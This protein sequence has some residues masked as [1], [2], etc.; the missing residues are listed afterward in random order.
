MTINN[1]VHSITRSFIIVP[2]LATTLSMNAFTAAIEKA[3][4]PTQ[5]SAQTPSAEEVELQATLED[6]AAKIDAY[7]AKNDMPLEGYGMKMVLEAQK[8]DLDWRIIPA[9]AVRESTGGKH[10]CKKAT[11]NPFGW[12]SCKI[13]FASY[14]KAIETLA[15]NLAGKNP[16]TARAYGNKSTRGILESYNPPSVVPTYASEVMSIMSRISVNA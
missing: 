14:D 12:G 13:S 16:N 10:A 5:A 7:Y 11:F 6:R 3:V 9:I 1:T 4:T 2:M 8:H 15:T